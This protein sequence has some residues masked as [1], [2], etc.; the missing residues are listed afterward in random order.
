MEKEDP[1]V[2]ELPESALREDG[3]DGDGND[4][5]WEV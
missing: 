3:P 4:K 1:I 2:I 5:L